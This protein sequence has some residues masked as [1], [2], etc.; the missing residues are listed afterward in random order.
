M[1]GRRNER[2][3]AM[4][5]IGQPPTTDLPLDWGVAS[6]AMPGES[7]T[8]DL[9]L[10]A[11]Y[12]GGFLFAVADGLGHGAGAAFAARQ[13]IATLAGNAALPVVELMRLSHEALHNTRGAALALVSLRHRDRTL[14][15]LSVGNVDAA[16]VRAAGG[17]HDRV[18]LRGG[19]VGHQLPPLRSTTASMARGDLLVVATDGVRSDFADD[20]RPGAPQVVADQVLAR[21]GKTSDDALVLAARLGSAP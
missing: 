18:V 20:L 17:R 19:V 21:F 2:L 8:G 4:E 1:K 14:Q 11:P 9:H 6:W 3:H 15:W 7:E 5:R 13:A 16:L 12:P 10:V